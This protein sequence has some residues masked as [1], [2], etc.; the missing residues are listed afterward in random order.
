MAKV[1]VDEDKKKMSG[2]NG[3]HFGETL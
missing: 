1:S 2:C 3:D